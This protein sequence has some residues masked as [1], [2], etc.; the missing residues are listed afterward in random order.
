MLDDDQEDLDPEEDLTQVPPA[1]D[2]NKEDIEKLK[3]EVKDFE[4]KWKRAIADYQNLERRTQELR[5]EWILS[6]N[7]D[8]ILK[9][10][11]VLDTL[12]LAQSHLKDE[13]LALSIQK[14]LDTLKDEGVQGIETKDKSF[15]PHHMEAVEIVSGEKDKVI[16]EVRQG[17]LLNDKV[18]RPA[19]VKVGDKK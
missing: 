3:T 10:L 9:M 17:F 13:G 19:Q 1:S 5:R 7:R 18:L 11:P 4:E 6:S 12:L 14:F 15:D 16:E 2:D 8:L